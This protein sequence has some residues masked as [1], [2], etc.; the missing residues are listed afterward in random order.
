MIEYHLLH[1]D[2]WQY[3]LWLLMMVVVVLR[4][5]GESCAI[6]LEE[7]QVL[8]ENTNLYIRVLRKYGVSQVTSLK[9]QF[10]AI[11]PLFFFEKKRRRAYLLQ[12][13][14]NRSEKCYATA[15]FFANRHAPPAS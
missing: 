5:L 12:H 7:A 1:F 4:V 15:S 2:Q 11:L 8:G 9:A 6:F 10:H 14:L 3:Y 13:L